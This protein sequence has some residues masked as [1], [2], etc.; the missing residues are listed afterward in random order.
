MWRWCPF[1]ACTL[2]LALLCCSAGCSVTTGHF[3]PNSQFA[4][5]NS[6]IKSLGTVHSEM[7]KTTWIVAP[8]LKLEDL[9]KCYSDALSQAAGANILINYREDTTFTA[10]PLYFYTVKYV[11][12]GEAARQEIGEQHLR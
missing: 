2:A 8:E 3:V 12:E 7:A 1:L 11:I 6:N 9:K 4:Y 5:P 10:W